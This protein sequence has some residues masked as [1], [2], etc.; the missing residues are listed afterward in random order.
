MRG[1]GV[2]T[3]R[4]CQDARLL[5]RHHAQP[6]VQAQVTVCKSAATA[7]LCFACLPHVGSFRLGYTIVRPYCTAVPPVIFLGFAFLDAQGFFGPLNFLKIALEVFLS[8]KTQ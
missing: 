2:A 7:R 8:I 6:C 1:V 3:A 4:P 5:V